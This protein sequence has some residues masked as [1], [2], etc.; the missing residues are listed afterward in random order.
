MEMPGILLTTKTKL[1]TASST[2]DFSIPFSYNVSYEVRNILKT[3]FKKDVER[4]IK[5]VEKQRS[6]HLHKLWGPRYQKSL[7]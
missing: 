6:V 4:N 1:S 7:L 3:E 5:S 2:K